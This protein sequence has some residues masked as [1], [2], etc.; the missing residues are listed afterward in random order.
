MVADRGNHRLRKIVGDQVTTLA[1]N[2]EVDRD[3]GTGAGA[4]FMHPCRVA[5]DERGCLLV[6]DVNRVNMLRVVEVL[7]APML[8]MGPVVEATAVLPDEATLSVL[9]LVP[10]YGK[11]VVEEQRFPAHGAVLA[12]QSEYFRGLVLSGRQEAR[13]EPS[14]PHEVKLGGASAVAFGVLL[15]NLYTVEVPAGRTQRGRAQQRARTVERVER[16]ERVEVVAARERV[17]RGA[18]AG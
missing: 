18:R 3:D 7:L 15:R 5:L 17:G 6:S 13:R 11:S 14:G 4:H 10:N 9:V 12:A 2:S 16:V 8:W 1:G